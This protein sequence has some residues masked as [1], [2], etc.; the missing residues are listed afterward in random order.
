MEM[1]DFC[2]RNQFSLS[3]NEYKIVEIRKMKI[4][5]KNKDEQ[6]VKQVRV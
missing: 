1:T 2:F 3:R 5:M 4:K 6:K